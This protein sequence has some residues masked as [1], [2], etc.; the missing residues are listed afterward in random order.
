MQL[1]TKQSERSYFLSAYSA[2]NHLVAPAVAMDGLVTPVSKTYRP[3][4]K[5]QRPKNRS[6]QL[7]NSHE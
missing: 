6:L 4:S 2:V 7:P 1:Y 3:S 5:F